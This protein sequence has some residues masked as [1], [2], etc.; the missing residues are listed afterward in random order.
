MTRNHNLYLN[1]CILHTDVYSQHHFI[2]F[3]F[4]K[5]TKL[6]KMFK[7]IRSVSKIKKKSDKKVNITPRSKIGQTSEQKFYEIF[8]GLCGSFLSVRNCFQNVRML[9]M[10]L[11]HAATTVLSTS[12]ATCS[13]FPATEMLVTLSR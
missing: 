4:Q 2:N 3:H 8:K 7:K 10:K 11:S 6:V 9:I 13:Y 5:T 1:I 12:R